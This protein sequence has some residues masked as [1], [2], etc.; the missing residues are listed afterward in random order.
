MTHDHQSHPRPTS[1]MDAFDRFAADPYAP[2]PAPLGDEAPRSAEGSVHAGHGAHGGHKWWMHLL[3]CGPMFAVVGYLIFTG[4]Y[5]LNALIYPVL[6]MVMMMAMMG[7]M[8]RGGGA[9]GSAG[10]RH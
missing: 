6:C 10:H 8:N 3:M 1:E 9:G 2:T 5:S 7:F 4:A